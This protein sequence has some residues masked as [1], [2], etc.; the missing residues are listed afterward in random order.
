[1]SGRA[2]VAISAFL[3]RSF[4]PSTESV[5]RADE[6]RLAEKDI[7][8]VRRQ[9]LSRIDAADARADAPHALHHG[10]KIDA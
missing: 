7:D 5:S 3:K 8:A 2:P 6:A 1:M 9:A 10:G 4:V